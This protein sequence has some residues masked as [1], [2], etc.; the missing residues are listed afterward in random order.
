MGPTAEDISAFSGRKALEPLRIYVGLQSAD[1]P[2][3]RAK[4]ALEELKRVGGF[5]RSVLIVLTPTGTGW[6]DPA[7]LDSVEYLHDGAVASVAVQYSYLASWL[8]LLAGPVYGADTAR[9]L[10]GD[11]RLLDHASQGEATEA[12]SARS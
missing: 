4:L 9:A 6:I 1:T 8:Y 5:E 10:Q 3:A 2:E 7:A 12:L 11:L